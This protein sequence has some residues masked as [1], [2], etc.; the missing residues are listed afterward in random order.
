[1]ALMIGWNYFFEPV[2]PKIPLIPFSPI[3]RIPLPTPE[4]VGTPIFDERAVAI[5]SIN[6]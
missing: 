3:S 6:D 2:I 4:T 5:W 1:M